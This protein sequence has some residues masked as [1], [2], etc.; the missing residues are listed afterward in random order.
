[1]PILRVSQQKLAINRRRRYLSPHTCRTGGTLEETI[2][3]I[4]L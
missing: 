2:A 4:F 1:M 3:I